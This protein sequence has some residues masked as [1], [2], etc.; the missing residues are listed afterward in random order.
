MRPTTC[1]TGPSL[2]LQLRMNVFYVSCGQANE[3]RPSKLRR[4]TGAPSASDR[5][6]NCSMA[7]LPAGSLPP[8]SGRISCLGQLIQEGKERWRLANEKPHVRM[9]EQIGRL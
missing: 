9:I 3:P 5:Q 4:R 2:Y 1:R 7:V 8:V 6:G